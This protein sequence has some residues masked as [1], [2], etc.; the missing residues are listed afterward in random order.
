MMNR[1][2]IIQV[3]EHTSN[4]KMFLDKNLQSTDNRFFYLN[5]SLDENKKVFR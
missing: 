4:I 5:Y 2:H 3:I 1:E